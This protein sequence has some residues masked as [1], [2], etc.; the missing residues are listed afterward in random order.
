[1]VEVKFY[2]NELKNRFEVTVKGHA[3]TAEIGKDVICASVSILSL[4]LIQ[5]IKN[6]EN[7]G[8]FVNPPKYKVKDGFTSVVCKPEKEYHDTVLNSLL[9][10]KVGFNILSEGFPEIVKLL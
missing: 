5:T 4:T 3:N 10:I 6:M 9:T 1:M 7:Q 8:F 2:E